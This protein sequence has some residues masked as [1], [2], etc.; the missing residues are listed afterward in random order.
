MHRK[1]GQYVLLVRFL[2]L[3]VVGLLLV[4]AMVTPLRKLIFLSQ[5]S[6]IEKIEKEDKQLETL[7][8]TAG[9]FAS[10]KFEKQGREFR[11]DGY[12][13]DIH[14]ITREGNTVV[15]RALRDLKETGLLAAVGNHQKTDGSA[16]QGISLIGFMPYFLINSFRPDFDIEDHKKVRYSILSMNLPDP[17]S[18]IIAPPPKFI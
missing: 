11:Y 17:G 12:M 9:A 1:P 7:V 2:S 5:T 4:P 3:F 14:T 18:G 15:V 6:R 16:I 8:F 13:Y 10:L